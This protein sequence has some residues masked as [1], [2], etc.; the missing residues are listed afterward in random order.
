MELADVM[1]DKLNHKI[2]DSTSRKQLINTLIEAIQSVLKESRETLR[3]LK[4][5][6]YHMKESSDAGLLRELPENIVLNNHK[7]K[8]EFFVPPT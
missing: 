3:S 1:L 7:E 6:L 2:L 8:D 4:A 5:M